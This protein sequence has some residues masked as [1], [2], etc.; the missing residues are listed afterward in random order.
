MSYH[1]IDSFMNLSTFFWFTHLSA[2]ANGARCC[3]SVGLMLGK[4]IKK[5]LI[6]I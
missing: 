6:A 5:L 2:S 1:M 3:A 4:M